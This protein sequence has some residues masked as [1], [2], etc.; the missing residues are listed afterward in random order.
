MKTNF[1]LACL[2]CLVFAIEGGAQTVLSRMHGTAA[3]ERFGHG[4]HA[5]SDH[6]GD[7]VDDFAISS[8]DA[9]N[10]QGVQ[11][12]VV[13]IHSGMNPSTRIASLYGTRLGGRFGHAVIEAELT[14]D[15]VPD[16]IVGAPGT[17]PNAPG[18]VPTTVGCA[19]VFDGR[20]FSMLP[21]QLGGCS[22]DAEGR[23]YSLANLGDLNA[24]GLDEV[25]VGIPY[26]RNNGSVIGKVELI[27]SRT[28]MVMAT[29]NGALATGQQGTSFG[30]SMISLQVDMSPSLELVVGAPQ[31]TA[32][33]DVV[34]GLY[35]YRWDA[36]LSVFDPLTTWAPSH[37]GVRY[38]LGSSLA[39]GEDLDG[40]NIQDILV[41]ASTCN[42]TATNGGAVAVISGRSMATTGGTPTFLFVPLPHFL[43]KVSG[44]GQQYYGLGLTFVDDVDGD[45]MAD[46]AVGG[47]NLG[48]AAVGGV[49]VFSGATGALLCSWLGGATLDQYGFSLARVADTNGD[50]RR[51][52]LIGA[53][54]EVAPAPSVR[55]GCVQVVSGSLVDIT[56]P[57]P[58][59]WLATGAQHMVSWSSCLQNACDVQFAP[60]GSTWSTI[61]TAQPA[62]GTYLWTT[63]L[64]ESPYCRLRIIDGTTGRAL[65]T[66]TRDFGISQA[67]SSLSGV[68]CGPGPLTMVSLGSLPRMGTTYQVGVS[69]LPSN[70][71]WGMW[72]GFTDLVGFGL[73]L[74]L[75]LSPFGFS[76]CTLYTELALAYYSPSGSTQWDFDVPAMSAASGVTFY[77]Q[78]VALDV[79][80]GAIYFSNKGTATIGL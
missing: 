79:P 47:P 26:D 4:V 36:V 34:G 30:E 76:G 44:V 43:L 16:I 37:A 46:F 59:A 57:Q 17:V 25:A 21:R 74:P 49:D 71:V 48:A 1:A 40:D 18:S 5:L 72:V 73:P 19:T 56:S 62:T 29:L 28:D 80:T 33:G 67:A 66:M 51:E 60:D 13:H 75:D 22:G 12:G 7:G 15:G 54:Q 10:L 6:D 50:G 2:P 39:T 3:L 42:A 65:G 78:A 11:A 64:T 68:G 63:P 53:A 9:T 35:A 58:G 8:I 52:I 24:D 41:S 23:A 38:G 45:G 32:G 27:D 61:A 77:H 70:T 14:G 69:G 31:F 55:A 20:T